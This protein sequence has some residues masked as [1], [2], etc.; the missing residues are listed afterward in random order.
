VAAAVAAVGVAHVPAGHG[1]ER[2]ATGVAAGIVVLALAAYAVVKRVRVGRG[3]RT[4][5][6]SGPESRRVPAERS[7]TR[8]HAIAHAALGALAVGV[9]AA[10]AGARVAPNAAGALLVAFA[11]ASA[12]GMAGALAYRL[13]PRA[14]SRVERRAM[15]PEDLGPRARDLDDRVFGALSGRSE[16]TKAVYA[17]WLAPYARWPLGG[18]ALIARRATPKEEERRLRG[19]VEAVLGARAATLDGLQDLVRLV[20]ERRAV[21]AQRLL[22][23]ALRA[24]VPAHVVA[25]AVTL[26]LL[27]VHVA[28]VVRAR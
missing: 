3:S 7:R 17:R 14:L 19:R 11:V 26:V 22:Q 15:L 8:L 4:L 2:V 21:R 12:T 24:W 5:A 9:V 18:L 10:H 13:A 28:L 23:G 6:E 25:V 16:A 27:L 20:V 1:A